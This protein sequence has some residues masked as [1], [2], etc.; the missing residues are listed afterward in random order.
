MELQ[1]LKN[2][3]SYWDLDNSE[4][5]R[6]DIGKTVKPDNI[7]ELSFHII[8]LNLSRFHF[9]VTIGY[10]FSRDVS[11]AH[12]SFRTTKQRHMTLRNNNKG[13]ARKLCEEGINNLIAFY[14][15]N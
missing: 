4:S 2:L 15:G 9:H 14:F 1:S 11:K 6:Q 10:N 12:S 7:R 8:S 13:L 3:K 5:E